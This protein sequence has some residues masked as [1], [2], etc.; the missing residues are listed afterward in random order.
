M[1]R[2]RTELLNAQLK[3]VDLAKRTKGLLP[4]EFCFGLVDTFIKHVARRFGELLRRGI[5]SQEWV[6]GCDARWKELFHQFCDEFE[7]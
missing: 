2:L 4:A 5:V 6:D 1:Q 3:Q 7:R